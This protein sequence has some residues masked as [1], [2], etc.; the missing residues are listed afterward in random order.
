MDIYHE[1]TLLLVIAVGVGFVAMMLRQPLII[2]YLAVG[3][4]VG[5]SALGM[6]SAHSQIDLLAH[7]G[8]TIL[9]FVVG[10]KL[11]LRIVK[12][13]GPV[14][15]ATGLGQLTFTILIGFLLTLAFGFS[16]MDALYTA[17]ALTFSS[18][19]IIVKLLSDKGE[20]E[21]LHGRIA[22]GFLI[23]QD[24][25]VV[26]AMMGL[27]LTVIDA[28]Q[29]GQLIHPVY[30][31]LLSLVFIAVALPLL[32]RYVI[33][34]LMSH[35]ARS[36]EM[37]IL[38]AIA[39]GTLLAA[40]ADVMGL[41]KEVGAFLAGFSLANTNVKDVIASRLTSLRDFLLLFFFIY[42]GQQLDLSLIGESLIP[43][44]A[45]SVFVLIGN[46]LIV[47]A[48]MG[49]MGYRRRTGF[50][51]GL[52]VAQISEFSIIFIAMGLSLGHVTDQVLGLVTLVGIITIT[53]STYMIMYSQQLYDRIKHLFGPFER[54]ITYREIQLEEP[55]SL[56]PVIMF[57][58]GRFG[59][60]LAC[61]LRERGD[62]VIGV[63][64]DPER[65]KRAQE[66]GIHAVFGDAEDVEFLS[67]LPVHSARWI[68]S[69]LP[70]REVNE[71]LMQGLRMFSLSGHIAI[72]SFREDDEIHWKNRNVN[73]ILHPYREAAAGAIEQLA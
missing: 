5:P 35:L 57:G 13:L 16:A 31:L 24:I 65:V 61:Q 10:L 6:V 20:L 60:R 43:A 70:V 34:Q 69:T 47:M 72:A 63:D 71:I 4:I 9:L 22:M 58:L 40:G 42:M 7:W 67:H 49:Y 26:A 54:R 11:D 66:E 23:V 8:I 52:T 3:I 36:V 45:L 1:F 56:R 48:I 28:D 21:T 38:F 18:T 15:L 64:I 73:L 55:V 44:L 27:N 25:A 68:I 19:I 37:L 17:I 12:S 2:A 33:P 46:P 59:R 41:S 14:A 50:K 53:T 51:A 29:E 32:M 62:H 39:W 30:G